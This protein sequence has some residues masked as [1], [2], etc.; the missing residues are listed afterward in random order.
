MFR[1]PSSPLAA[2][3]RIAFSFSTRPS[4]FLTS[5]PAL[6]SHLPAHYQ[7]IA[8][9]VRARP[10]NHLR[11]KNT[12]K[13]PRPTGCAEPETFANPLREEVGTAFSEESSLCR[14]FV[15]CRVGHLA[16]P[17]DRV[18]DREWRL[19]LVIAMERSFRLRCHILRVGLA[20]RPV[21]LSPQRENTREIKTSPL[22]REAKNSCL[23]FKFRQ[24][25]RSPPDHGHKFR[26]T[27]PIPC[28]RRRDL[29]RRGR[30][31]L[32]VRSQRQRSSR[33]L[34]PRSL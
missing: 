14:G 12:R 21:S 23:R 33:I 15:S 9:K 11:T 32:G 18:L 29:L 22:L 25:P 4:R 2:S 27:R 24:Q 6:P 3:S 16:D 31:R 1:P 20:R 7:I 8:G 5:L 26:S 28:L 13:V 34:G 19:L 17:G 30:L 10:P